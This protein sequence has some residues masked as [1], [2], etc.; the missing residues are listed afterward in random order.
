VTRGENGA[1]IYAGGQFYGIPAVPPKQISDP[2]GAGDA[3][4]GGLLRG[5]AAG[6]GWDVAGRMGALAAT[7][8]LETLGPINHHYTRAEFVVRYR[9]HFDDNGLLDALKEPTYAEPR[10]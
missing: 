6:W 8:C 3:F 10:H 9:E 1:T 2:T 5:M 7:Y 4:R